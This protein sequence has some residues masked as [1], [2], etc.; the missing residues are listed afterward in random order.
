MKLPLWQPSEERKK[1]A[2]I[3]QAL[4][5]VHHGD[6]LSHETGREIQVRGLGENVQAFDP[7]GNSVT[8][9]LK[10]VRNVTRLCYTQGNQNVKGESK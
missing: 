8:S 4:H 5:S 6:F 10:E 2:K 7:Q 9:S 1:R 3:V